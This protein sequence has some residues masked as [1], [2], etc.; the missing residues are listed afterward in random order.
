MLRKNESRRHVIEIVSGT[1]ATLEQES[2]FASSLAALGGMDFAD[3]RP[4]VSS[5]PYKDIDWPRTIVTGNMHVRMREQ[6]RG[7]PVCF[8]FDISHS[9]LMSGPRSKRTVG[10]DLLEVLSEAALRRNCQLN[11]MLFSDRIEFT[12]LHIAHSKAYEHALHDI[13]VLRPHA[14]R[15]T[16]MKGLLQYLA[17]ILKTPTL[18]IIISDFLCVSGWQDDFEFL[19]DRN[20]V[21]PLVIEDPRDRTGPPGFAY[22]RGIESGI[23]RPAYGGNAPVNETELFFELLKKKGTIVWARFELNEA[24]D[25]CYQRLIDMF[26]LLE[27]YI[28]IRSRHRR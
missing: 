8:A 10:L 9:L 27:E 3:V 7:I 24:Q 21:I 23:V 2:M 16:D 11:Y 19:M 1:L 5:D 20:E 4:R 13:A 26:H 22:C 12:R 18:I 14:H 28:S 25:S 15:Q 6:E 17:W